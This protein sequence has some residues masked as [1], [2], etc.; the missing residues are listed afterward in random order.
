MSYT[1]WQDI[2]EPT[3]KNK[4][5]LSILEFGLGDGTKYL[6]DN[7]KYVYSYE[8]IDENDS[9]LIDWYNQAA[10]KFKTYSNWGSE[11]VMWQDIGFIDPGPLYTGIIPPELPSGLLL[12]I[13]ELF[14]KYKFN[15][16]L[17]DGGF[18]VRGDIANYI[19][20]NFPIEYVI[21]HDINYNFYVDGY[22]RINLPENYETVKYTEG[23]GTYIFVKK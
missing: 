2:V 1:D 9:T 14:S 12:R 17:V 8:L 23:N 19:L 18:H 15:A 4:N 13:D 7:F 22:H 20:N 11:V 3:I 21:I 5:Q 6:L 10:D 16:V